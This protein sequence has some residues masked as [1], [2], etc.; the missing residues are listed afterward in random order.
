MML[1]SFSFRPI[2]IKIMS[3]CWKYVDERANVLFYL[4]SSIFIVHTQ[5]IRFMHRGKEFSQSN[6]DIYLVGSIS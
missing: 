6:A 4:F 5:V 3:L 2:A 1:F